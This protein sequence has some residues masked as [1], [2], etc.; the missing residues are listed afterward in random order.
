M[1]G[2]QV[3]AKYENYLSAERLRNW[4][5]WKVVFP[6]GMLALLYPIY[7]FVLELKHPYEKAFAHGDLL[8]FSVLI[9]LEAAI[10][11]EHLRSKDGWFHVLMALAKVGAVLLILIFG[12]MKAD[13]VLQE[14]RLVPGGDETALLGKLYAY[15]TFSWIVTVLSVI[16]SLLM[17]WT[18]VAR[19]C[20]ERMTEMASDKITR[21]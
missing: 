14:T 18:V 9:L 4:C 10:E 3:A 21:R 20:A 7:R 17:F 19:E 11:G 15:S 6:L 8:L 1:N 13:V 5:V 16:Y 2:A 12:F